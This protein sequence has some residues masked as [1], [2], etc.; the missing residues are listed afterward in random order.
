MQGS[1]RR[2]YFGGCSVRLTLAAIS[3]LVWLSLRHD[4]LAGVQG[5]T[6]QT[7]HVGVAGKYKMGH[8]TQ[9][10]VVVRGGTADSEAG[11]RVIA[12]DGDGYPVEFEPQNSPAVAIP[13]GTDVT[14]ERYVKLGRISDGLRV[15]LVREG[16][17]AARRR[18]APSE[19]PAPL[20][21]VQPLV[22]TLGNSIGIEDAVKKRMRSR[23]NPIAT[24]RV[25]DA[26]E[27]P[28]QWFGY[29]SVDTICVTTSDSCQLEA[30]DEQQFEAVDRWLKMGGR[31][32]LCVGQRGREVFREDSRLSRYCPGAGP[33]VVEQR[34]TS[35]LVEYAGAT[36]RLDARKGGRVRRFSVPMTVIHDAR[37]RVE[38]EEIVG[39]E[40][41][42]PTIVRFPY[43]L[44]QIV[45]LAFDLDQK[46]FADWQGREGMVT[47]ILQGEDAT[48]HRDSDGE[49][50]LGQVA[51]L[52]FKDLAGQ[53]RAALDQFD[54]VTRVEF[55]WIAALIGVYVLL[56]GPVDY[57]LL[58][59]LQ[60]SY[61]TWITLPATVGLFC[62][63][64]WLLQGRLSGNQLHIN[65]VECVDLDWSSRALRGDTWLHLYSPASQQFDLTLD[66]RPAG[67]GKGQ[68]LFA[69]QSLPGVGLGG[70]DSQSNTSVAARRYGVAYAGDQG[71]ISRL[72]IRISSSKSLSARWTADFELPEDVPAPSL[73]VG[74]NGLL[75]GRIVNPFDVELRDCLILYEN[76]TFSIPGSFRSGGVMRVDGLEPRNLEW[77]LT[78]R[79]VVETRD[80]STPWDQASF[81]VPRIM[82]NMMFHKAAG[83]DSYTAG[84]T[85][86]CHAY[87]D[88][89]D[90]LRTGRAV[91]TGRCD[92]PAMDLRRDGESLDEFCDRRWTI[93]RVVF[94]VSKPGKAGTG[95]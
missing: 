39:A 27:L 46:P 62:G 1:S 23:S 66:A 82:E 25:D 7:V 20:R 29:E 63:L 32:I 55:S 31:M 16:Q 87:L 94:P 17:I 71:A 40:G 65:Q 93:Y 33:D 80:V 58:R 2:S 76:W 59:R 73:T 72:P 4:A 75:A 56:V 90:H 61:W 44:G 85:H 60:R 64:A 95:D 14:V 79:R 30:V 45:F 91:L 24:G 3:L 19:L 77:R 12:S 49:D 81:D 50:G 8:W 74:P 36:E 9:V 67:V 43:G 47:R 41:R 22:V 68:A 84:L 69:W 15:E 38:S 5:P 37:G 57:F 11:V 89:S 48:R 92:K 88:L 86:R 28:R 70:V 51:H 53:L 83:G 10:R 35:G 26:G 54:G 42:V 34:T 52:G 78:R 6:I 18:F 13:A 21:S